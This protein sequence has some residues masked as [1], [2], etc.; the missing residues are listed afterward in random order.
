M[1]K[2]H[3]P[4]PDDYGDALCDAIEALLALERAGGR[5]DA[6]PALV[7]QMEQALDKLLLPA[8][9]KRQVSA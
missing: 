1:P 5:F 2:Q 3:P 8:T 9:A 6:L 4:T 7:R